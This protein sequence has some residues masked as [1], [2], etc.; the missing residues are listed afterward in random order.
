[1]TVIDKDLGLARIMR[2]LAR[3]DGSYV[4][5]GIHDDAGSTDEGTSV[6]Q[7]GAFHE[8]GV[9]VPMRA[10]LRP[11][12]DEKTS[13]IVSLA[14]DC[15]GKIIDGGM[16]TPKALG[17]IGE[18]AQGQVQKT[19]RAKRTEWPA[20]AAATI[21]RKAKKGGLRG[22]KRAS[23]LGGTGNPLIDTGQLMQSIRYKR[24]IGGA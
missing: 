17:L 22:K 5:V 14:A 8:F 20:L 9:G 16:N 11:T 24:H 2:E 13:E 18:Y 1:M 15:Y 7:V 21:A 23:F 10:F 6:A 3:A 19:L 4:T 12:I